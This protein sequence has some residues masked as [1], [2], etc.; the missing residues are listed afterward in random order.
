MGKGS[1]LLHPS[2]FSGCF[3]CGEDGHFVRD[4]NVSQEE[5]KCSWPKCKAKGH[6]VKACRKKMASETSTPHLPKGQSRDRRQGRSRSES[7]G[8]SASPE[9]KTKEGRGRKTEKKKATTAARPK[10]R[11]RSKSADSRKP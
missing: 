10:S 1:S 8:K 5:A 4:C 2:R 7:R 3:I 11:S 6:L 9:K